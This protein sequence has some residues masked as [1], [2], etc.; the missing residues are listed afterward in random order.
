MHAHTHFSMDSTM[1]QSRRIKYMAMTKLNTL[2]H[3][4]TYH[5]LKKYCTWH[6][7]KRVCIYLLILSA[8]FIVLAVHVNCNKQLFFE[9]LVSKGNYMLLHGNILNELH[10]I[11]FFPKLTISVSQVFRN[12]L[13]TI[14]GFPNFWQ[15]LQFPTSGQIISTEGQLL[16][17]TSHQEVYQR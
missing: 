3:M 14:A 6:K 17:Q 4:P 13:Q 8:S 7:H 11:K 12:T 16:T 10:N 1:P 9:L 5:H 15:T 2:L